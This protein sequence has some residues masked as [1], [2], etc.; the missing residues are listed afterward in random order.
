MDT[1]SILKRM[2]R[3][4]SLAS[5]ATTVSSG[6]QLA[7]EMQGLIAMLERSLAAK[8]E[9]DEGGAP[10]YDTVEEMLGL[11]TDTKGVVPERDE[12]VLGYDALQHVLEAAYRQASEGKGADRHANGRSFADQP[13]LRI[14]EMLGAGFP[15]GQAMKKSQEACSMSRRGEHEKAQHELLG[16]IVYLAAAHILLEGY[17]S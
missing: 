1:E 17:R 12:G 16:A 10:S 6:Q 4:A 13:I 8:P 15:I 9:P 14:S 3:V 2:K 7:Q 5:E 11:A